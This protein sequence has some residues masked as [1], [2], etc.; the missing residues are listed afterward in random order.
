MI[1]TLGLK[2]AGAAMRSAGLAIAVCAG[3]LLGAAT[4]AIAQSTPRSECCKQLNGRWEANRRTGEMRCFG[5]SS[6]PYYQCVA[7]RTR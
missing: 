7:K 4:S 2:N 3:V 5:V 6:T 1:F